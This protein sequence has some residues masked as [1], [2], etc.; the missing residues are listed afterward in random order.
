LKNDQLAAMAMTKQPHGP[1][2]TLGDMRH[3]GVRN[4]I[5]FRLNAACRHQGLIDVSKYPDNA[6]VRSGPSKRA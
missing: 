5:A 4:L 3:L 1:P 6:E 2:M